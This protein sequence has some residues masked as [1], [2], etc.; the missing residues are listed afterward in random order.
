[1]MTERDILMSCKGSVLEKMFNGLH[2]LK[3]ID[4][5]V[6][7]DRDGKTFSHLVNYLRND[8]QIMPEFLDPNEE[9]QF[10]K[11]LEFWNIPFKQVSSKKLSP[12]HTQQRQT[13]QKVN[14]TSVTSA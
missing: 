4:D 13:V 7:L 12:R 5:E 11:E 10:Y 2:E 1:M 6:F 8:R 14:I 9:K 3:I